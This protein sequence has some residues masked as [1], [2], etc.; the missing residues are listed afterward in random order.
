MCQKLTFRDFIL[1][2]GEEQDWWLKIEGSTVYDYVHITATPMTDGGSVE[3]VKQW[4]TVRTPA[5]MEPY[6]G[7]G[8]RYWVRFKNNGEIAVI[9][10][11][12]A[13]RII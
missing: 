3:I 12:I 13:C 11:P 6:L 9:V 8:V 1:A 10:H 7:R 4:T 5:G 2:P